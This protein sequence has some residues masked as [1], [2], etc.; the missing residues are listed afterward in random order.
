[1][2]SR[3]EELHEDNMNKENLIEELLKTTYALSQAMEGKG[4]LASFGI[5]VN[6]Q[7]VFPEGLRNLPKDGKLMKYIYDNFIDIGPEPFN[8]V[9]QIKSENQSL[10]KLLNVNREELLQLQQSLESAQL[11]VNNDRIREK[12]AKTRKMRDIAESLLVILMNN[13]LEGEIEKN[14]QLL[15]FVQ[16]VNTEKGARRDRNASAYS[17]KS[18]SSDHGSILGSFGMKTPGAGLDFEIADLNKKIKIL[19]QKLE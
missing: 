10:Q 13:N 16:T 17:K 11:R 14:K 5:D 3:V 8:T 15:E 9:T 4:P 1:M 2:K 6:P 18:R 19:E 7:Y 12:S